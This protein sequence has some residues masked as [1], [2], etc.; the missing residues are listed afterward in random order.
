MV[1]ECCGREIESGNEK[2][3]SLDS[4][5]YVCNDCY[6]D[7]KEIKKG[8]LNSI[9]VITEYTTDSVK[10][11]ISYCEKVNAYSGKVK[12]YSDAASSLN[13]CGL[14][15]R[16]ALF[17]AGCLSAFLIVFLNTSFKG[18]IISIYI[19]A[20]ISILSGF[21][22]GTFFHA[23]CQALAIWTEKNYRDINMK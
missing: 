9:D 19:Y 13:T 11:Y 21:L 17:I 1:C 7:I 8:A 5:I 10:S 18:N 23:L 22:V 4:D 20:I 15:G 3:L 14:I 16:F 6:S 12:Y 2:I